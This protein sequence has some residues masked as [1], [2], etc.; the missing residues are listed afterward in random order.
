MATAEVPTPVPAGEPTDRDITPYHRPVL[1]RLGTIRGSPCA[2]SPRLAPRPGTCRGSV[3]RPW[4]PSSCRLRHARGRPSDR[5]HRRTRHAARSRRDRAGPRGGGPV[6]ARV[7]HRGRRVRARRGLLL[8]VALR[9]RRRKRDDTLPAQTHGNNG[10]EMLWTVIPAIVVTVMFVV[11]TSVLLK[12]DT[13]TAAPAVTVDV[14]GFQWQWTFDYQDQGL[15]YT[16]AGQDGPEMVA[17]GRRDRAHPAACP[18]RHPLLL[19]ARSSSARRTWCRAAST[20]SRSTSR[21]KAPTAASAPSSAASPTRTCTSRSAPSTAP[22]FDQWVADEQA[23]AAE[24][25]PPPPSG[26]PEAP[27]ATRLPAERE[28]QP[29]LRPEDPDRARGPAAD[30][31]VP[32]PGPGGPAQRRHQGAASP[33]ARTGSACP[34]PRPGQTAIYQA[35][36]LPAGDVHLL[37]Q[38]APQ[39][40]RHARRSSKRGHGMATTT[41]PQAAALSAGLRSTSGSPPST[42]RRSGSCT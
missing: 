14:T 4:R 26:G 5:R 28:Q 3:S 40:D 33:M 32:E 38:R 10:L 1:E 31:R 9:F 36:P 29:R 12:V 27:P 2:S 35:P 13:V 22:T 19:R 41:L 17:A 11:S 20:S 25:P 6:P 18:G 39:H 42:T 7:H 15:S 8:F 21:R 30:H 37:L 34:S 16:G 23:K 24:T